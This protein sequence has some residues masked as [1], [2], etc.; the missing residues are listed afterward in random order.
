MIFLTVEVENEIFHELKELGYC[1]DEF[2]LTQKSR[3]RYELKRAKK[4]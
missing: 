2:I 1:L 4:H 3:Y